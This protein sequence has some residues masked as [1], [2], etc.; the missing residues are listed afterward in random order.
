MMKTISFFMLMMITYASFNVLTTNGANDELKTYIVHLDS[1]PQGQQYLVSDAKLN[2]WYDSFLLKIALKFPSSDKPTMVFSYRHAVTGF[3]AKMSQAQATAMANLSG[4]LNVWPESIYHLHTTRSPEFLGLRTSPNGLW[5]HSNKGK[6]VIIG[7]I[8]TG[9]TP[10][11][12]SFNDDGMPPPP[13]KWKGKCEIEGCNNKLIGM[14][15]FVNGSSPKDVEGHGTHTSST[16]AGSSVDNANVYEQANGTASGMA[17]LAHLAMYKVCMPLGCAGSAIL[18]GLDAAIEDGVDV[19]SVSLGSFIAF[20]FYKDPIAIAGF[21]AVQKGVF[22]S[23]SAGNSG[24][25]PS[26]VTN[27]APWLLTVGASTQ[28]RRIRT[29][30]WLGNKVLVNGES[31]YQP[32]DFEQKPRPLVYP[33]QHSDDE[34]VKYCVPGSFKNIDVNDK[35]VFCDWG[36]ISDIKKGQIVKEAGG[37]GVIIANDEIQGQSTAAY[38]HVIPASNVGYKEGVEIKKYLNSTSSPFATLLFFGTVDGLKTNPQ[39][40]SFSSRGPSIITPGILKPDVTGPGVNIIAAWADSNDTSGPSGGK[41]MFEVIR[42]TSMSCP[43]LAGVSALLK[44]DHP[45]WSPAAIKSA[46]MTTASQVDRNGVAIVDE[47]DHPADVLAIGSGHVNPPKATDPGLIFD[48][49]PDDYIPYLCGLG[50]TPKQV[51]AIVRKPVSCSKT[52]QEG[53]L[54]IPSFTVSLKKGERKTYSRT[55]TN[56]GKPDSIYTIRDKSLPHG[57]SIEIETGTKELEVKE[58]YEKI[59]YNVTFIRDVN[60]EEK[61]QFGQGHMTWECGKYLVRTPFFFKFE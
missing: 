45:D 14:R 7:L 22:I 58:M 37:A 38:K 5:T 41:G 46:I 59:T 48:I 9:I 20:P 49:Q 17:P 24:P 55:V 18:A 42:G 35:I 40:A 21:S 27:D 12:P 56:V 11:H 44:S 10:G 47:R 51:E 26:S 60:D 3:A 19:I 57:V 30:V 53:E 4:V 1:H 54:N 36:Q 61:G 2:E 31:L 32:K 39:M 43:H 8:D 52:I 29:S 15:S 23:C 33:G 25:I 50:Y 16:A 34:K 13:Q 28:D 6:G